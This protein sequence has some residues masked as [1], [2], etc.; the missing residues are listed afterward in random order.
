MQIKNNYSLEYFDAKTLSTGEGVYN[1]EI[2]EVIEKNDIDMSV[3]VRFED[4]K[5]VRYKAKEL[6]NL[7]LAYAVTVHKAQGCEFDSCIVVLGK[8][9]H[10]LMR[11]NILYTA[12]TRGRKKVIIIDAG[13]TLQGFLSSP[14]GNQRNTSLRDLLAI[15]DHKGI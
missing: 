12:V 13:N 15:I 14:S 5:T 4:G 6:D 9:N 8:M 1:G 11:R 10:M 3:S 7:E 2:G